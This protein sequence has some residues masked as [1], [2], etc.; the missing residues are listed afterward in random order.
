MNDLMKIED[1][2]SINIIA[3][4]DHSVEPLETREIEKRFPEE[5]RRKLLYRLNRLRGDGLIKGKMVGAS[6]GTWIW[7]K[8]NAF[9]GQ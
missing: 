8:K 2:I 5:S 6:R 4:L 3:I 1:Q 7:W 9:N